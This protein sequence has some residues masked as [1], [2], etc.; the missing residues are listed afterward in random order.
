MQLLKQ[1]GDFDLLDAAEEALAD[2]KR[3]AG[4]R[5]GHEYGEAETVPIKTEEGKFV[6]LTLTAEDII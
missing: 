6:P 1:M 5:S 4:S 3:A 2:L